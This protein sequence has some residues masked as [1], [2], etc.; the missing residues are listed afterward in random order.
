M[1]VLSVITIKIVDFTQGYQKRRWRS[2][3]GVMKELSRGLERSGSYFFALFALTFFDLHNRSWLGLVLWL[4]MARFKGLLILILTVY[5][6]RFPDAT[7][8]QTGAFLRV[9]WS[10]AS[11]FPHCQIITNNVHRCSPKSGTYM[12]GWIADNRCYYCEPRACHREQIVNNWS[13]GWQAILF[14]IKSVK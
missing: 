12:A 10:A 14:V 4:S 6:W 5:R 8:G 1:R 2:Y 9:W 13:H 11:V 7:E 3:E